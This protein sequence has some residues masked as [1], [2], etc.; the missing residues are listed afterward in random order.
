[1]GPAK[2]DR[3]ESNRDHGSLRERVVRSLLEEIVQGNIPASA[4]LVTQDLEKRFKTSATP[5]REALAELAGMGVIELL[6]NRGATVKQ[7]T[8]REVRELSQ[9]RRALECEAVRLAV[10]RVDIEE[11]KKLQNELEALTD[12]QSE[13]RQ[14]VK[15][16]R[17]LDSRLHDLI[18]QSSNNRFLIREL[19]RFSVLFRCFRDASW[20]KASKKIEKERLIE[21]AQEHQKIVEALL[22]GN[23]KLAVQAMRMHIQSTLGYWKV[24]VGGGARG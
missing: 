7:F 15:R 10:G 16:A 11:L 24:S 18:A 14:F 13:S 4:R 9:V 6:P 23:R 1:M 22:A 12:K 20:E 5:I 17:E 8:L 19:D 21:E 3:K 2:S